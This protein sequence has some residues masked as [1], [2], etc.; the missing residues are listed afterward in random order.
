MELR[1]PQT[2][3]Q[4]VE[5]AYRREDIYNGDQLEHAADVVFIPRRLEYFGFG[6]YEFGSHKVIEAMQRG[7]SGTHRMNGIFLAYGATVH[8]GVVEDARI[9]DLAPTILHLMGLPIPEHMDGRVLQEILSGVVPVGPAPAQPRQWNGPSG[10]QEEELSEEDLQIL[11]DRLRSL[12]YV[13]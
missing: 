7:I 8:P 4:V 9:L 3:E 6:E 1:D 12:G 11:T 13:G 10:G 5:A 2:G